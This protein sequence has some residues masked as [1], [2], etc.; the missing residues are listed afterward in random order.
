[1]YSDFLQFNYQVYV[2]KHEIRR[3]E[4]EANEKPMYLV[5]EPT[6]SIEQMKEDTLKERFRLT[7]AE[8]QSIMKAGWEV[9]VKDNLSLFDSTLKLIEY[10]EQVKTDEMRTKLDM[11]I[12]ALKPVFEKTIADKR[13][14]NLLQ[15]K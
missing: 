9:E 1:M 13:D 5:I 7:L 6:I 2:I 8:C 12:K 15:M 10:F 4:K 11:H 3:R 14:L